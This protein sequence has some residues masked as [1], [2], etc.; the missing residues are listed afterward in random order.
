MAPGEDWRI[1][2]REALVE[3]QEY[4]V[5]YPQHQRGSANRLL[6]KIE[7]ALKHLD[8]GAP[9]QEISVAVGGEGECCG[10]DPCERTPGCP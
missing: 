9:Q 4:L 10:C 1:A 7:A 5:H 6:S 2:A 8:N 3:C